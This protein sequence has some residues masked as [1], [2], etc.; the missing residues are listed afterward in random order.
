MQCWLCNRPGTQRLITVWRAEEFVLRNP[1]LCDLCNEQ[2]PLQDG[3][4]PDPQFLRELKAVA[5]GESLLRGKPEP[6]PA[7]VEERRH[8][9]RRNGDRRS[10]DRRNGERRRLERR[11]TRSPYTVATTS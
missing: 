7:P 6:D 9:D 1:V 2:L 11:G 5:R 10:G 8:R 4:M 3:V